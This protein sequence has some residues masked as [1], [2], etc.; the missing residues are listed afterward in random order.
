MSTR[1]KR[2]T[3]PPGRTTL[4]AES[5][6]APSRQKSSAL[7]SPEGALEECIGAICLVEVTLHSLESQESST[8]EQEVL[9]RAL[10]AIWSVHDWIYELRPDDLGGEDTDREDGQ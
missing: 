1:R 3:A 9:K 10:K 7:V 5:P 6:A 4:S 8:P 2:Q